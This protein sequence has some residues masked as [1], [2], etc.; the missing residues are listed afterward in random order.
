MMDV[1]HGIP[2]DWV[3]CR[4]GEVSAEALQQQFALAFQSQAPSLFL[5]LA[6]LLPSPHQRA[7]LITAASRAGWALPNEA[8][9]DGGPKESDQENTA[10]WQPLDRSRVQ[11]AAS[12]LSE[13]QV[14]LNYI[15][16]VLQLGMMPLVVR[17]SFYAPGLDS[18][19]GRYL[20]SCRSG[21]PAWKP[22]LD[23]DNLVLQA[24]AVG[25][26]SAAEKQQSG[27]PSM[28]G[29]GLGLPPGLVDGGPRPAK[30]SRRC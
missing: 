17:D 28:S 3:L 1:W 7:Q 5:E 20:D 2:D 30:R 4:Q 13:K 11:A 18:S 21:V 6:E 14:R 23:T 8:A 26:A 15:V 24:D 25:A 9:V 19:N 12:A 29:A 16:T 27:M 10:S 22:E